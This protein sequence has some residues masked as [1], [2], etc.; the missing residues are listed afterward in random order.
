M[1]SIRHR[2]LSGELMI[3][4]FLNLGSHI[5]AEI[6]GLAGF[7]WVLVDLEHGAGDYESLLCQLQAIESTP[8]TP[9]VRIVWNEAPHFKRVLD[10]GASG[11]MV[12]YVN[13]AEEA[14]RAVASMSYPPKGIR[15][16]A[17]YNRACG[18]GE[19]FESYFNQVN[20]HLLTVVQIET[21]ESVENAEAIA[22]V[23]GVDVLFLG[24]LDLGINLGTYPK[25]DHPRFREAVRKVAAA[26][27][28][29][30]KAAGINLGQS[31]E[32]ELA[33]ADGYRFISLGSDSGL[34]ARGMK[35]LATAF[36]QYKKSLS[37]LK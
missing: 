24:P 36:S 27:Q 20:D 6:A 34:V 3:G 12:P 22:A 2:T 30:G 15:G 4:T 26:C 21:E 18:F 8:T 31:E 19:S 32:I 1:K 14:Q 17:K 28:K 7:D 5:T 37:E 35:V 16:V 33:I 13:N 9:I 11:I 25:K 10:L 29:N 23:N